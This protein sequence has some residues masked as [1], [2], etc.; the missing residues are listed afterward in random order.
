[1]Q[2]NEP[3]GLEVEILQ[4]ILH[5]TL[6]PQDHLQMYAFYFIWTMAFLLCNIVWDIV[7]PQT[8]KFHITMLKEKTHILH[9]ATVFC[10]SILMLAAVLD[11][12]VRHLTTES[13]VPLLL[14]GASGVLTAIPAL[15]PYEHRPASVLPMAVTGQHADGGK[16]E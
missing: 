10:T 1:L 3:I 9:P 16:R 4:K 13:F 12:H 11:E 7:S 15:C 5:Y 2:E 6:L 14:A 8:P